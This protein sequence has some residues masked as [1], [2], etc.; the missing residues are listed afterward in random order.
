[1]SLYVMS[2]DASQLSVEVAVPVCSGSVLPVHSTVISDGHSR[3]GGVLSSMKMVWLHVLELPHASSAFHVRVIVY[4]CGHPP[5]TLT[6]VEVITNVEQ[7][8]VADAVPVLAGNVLAVHS[9]VR[10][11]GHDN[12]GAVKSSTVIV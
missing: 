1:M 10:L 2:G 9:I 7:L 6:S 3:M 5:A 11:P 8:S 4:S 12:P